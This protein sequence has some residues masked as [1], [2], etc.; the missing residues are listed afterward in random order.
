MK[1]S[2]IVKVSEDEK[3]QNTNLLRVFSNAFAANDIVNIQ[4]M[5]HDQGVYFG[6]MNKMKAIGYF[7]KLFF[8]EDGVHSKFNI[9]INRGF[10]LGHFSGQEVLEFRWSDF[11]PFINPPTEI[12]K[13]FGT[14]EN[15]AINEKI[16]RFAFSFKEGKI[17][18][19]SIPDKF[20]DTLGDLIVNN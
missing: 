7:Y 16:I 15:K 5:L 14:K 12:M 19:I 2:T 9:D 13:P 11:D 10:A 1:N 6:K 20:I 17:Y 4:N 3:L 8:A 18:S